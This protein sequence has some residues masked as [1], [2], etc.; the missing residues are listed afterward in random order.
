MIQAE[1]SNSWLMRCG[2]FPT[3]K[4]YATNIDVL[5]TEGTMLKRE[6]KCIH[7]RE[8][9]RKMASVMA[10]F[11]YVFVL[12]SATDI[13]RLAAI[14]EAAKTANKQMFVGQSSWHKRWFFTE[15][16]AKLSRG[17]F[18][19]NPLFYTDRLYQ[20]MKRK[21]MV[22]VVDTSQ[23]DRVKELIDKLPQEETLLIYSSWEGYYKDPEQV[24]VNPKY[25][26]F[27]EMF[28]NVIDIHTSSHADR[29]TIE[30][31]IRIIN[32]KE[33]ICIYKEADACL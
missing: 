2:L 14:K 16:E 29:Q 23:K 4:K 6:D 32:P 33:V 1:E 13:E 17:L 31:V 25:K 24:K 20:L 18:S 27:R 12:V 7:E 15:R 21:G 9:S 26:N 11:K 30:K 3:L 22:M 28:Y 5:I 8:V 10:A 19:F